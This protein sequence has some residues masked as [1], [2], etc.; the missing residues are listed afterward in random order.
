M[1]GPSVWLGED[2]TEHRKQ[3]KGPRAGRSLVYVGKKE[4][5]E[6]LTE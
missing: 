5:D 4:A 6:A 2:Y 3:Y 1:K